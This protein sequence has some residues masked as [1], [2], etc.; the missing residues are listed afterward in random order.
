MRLADLLHDVLEPLAPAHL[1]ESWDKVGLHVGDG[2]QRI[3]RAMLCIDLTEPVLAEAVRKRVNLV[4]A[5]HPP[6]FSPLE[7]LTGDTWKERVIAEC[8]RRRIALYSPHTALDSVQGGLNDWL[9]EGI[10]RGTPKPIIAVTER[11][12]QFK[13]VTFVPPSHVEKVR[14]AMAKAHA[15]VIGQY[16]E[17]SFTTPGTGT[18]RG[19]EGANPYVGKP[20]RLES[21]EELRLEMV[22]PKHLDYVIHAL[23][24][25]HPYE[26][27]A[28]DIF[29]LAPP[30]QRFDD[31][32]GSGRVLML[33]RPITPRTLVN[34]LK[35]HLGVKHLELAVPSRIDPENGP[36]RGSIKTVAVC[37]GAGHSLLSRDGASYADAWF[38]GEMRHHDVLDAVQEGRVVVLAGHTQTERPYLPIYRQRILEAGGGKGIE[39]LIS[40]ADAAPGVVV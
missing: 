6:I 40:E 5:Y 2:D 1:A 30:P 12:K 16:V 17:C 24:G 15:G 8:I 21:V 38:T 29:E 28:F 4:I 18:F 34:R 27:P 10:G 32:T 19:V 3:R 35:K 22:C 31:V 11:A 26:E 14:K 37:A 7:R 9:C 20:G 25:A 39:W 33:N 13:I 36:Y 23:R